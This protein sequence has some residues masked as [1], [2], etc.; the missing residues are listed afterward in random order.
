ME[1]QNTQSSNKTP[2]YIL[3]GILV[4]AILATAAYVGGNLL[5]KRHTNSEKENEFKVLAAEGLPHTPFELNGRVISQEGNILFVQAKQMNET[6]DMVGGKGVDKKDGSNSNLGPATE[7][8]INHD[9]EFYRDA[10]WEP[11][12]SGTVDKSDLSG[13]EIQQE[14]VP[15][16]ADELVT[17]SDVTIW[18][19]RNGDRVVAEFILYS[20]PFPENSGK[21]FLEE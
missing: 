16:S 12:I 20:L 6:L 19:E 13:D 15:G 21:I 14:I 5:Q 3:I 7:V 8:V 18:G 11:F 4:V 10:T 2:L 9:T 1:N 17:G